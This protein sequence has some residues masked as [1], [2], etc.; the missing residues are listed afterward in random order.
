MST[1]GKRTRIWQEIAAEASRE[2][3][4]EKRQELVRELELALD[5]RDAAKVQPEAV[6]T[7]NCQQSA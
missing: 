3:D 6:P 5:A 4:P 2:K 7:K 1:D